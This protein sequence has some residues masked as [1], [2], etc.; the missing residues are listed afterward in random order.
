MIRALRWPVV[1]VLSSLLL[2]GLVLGGVHSPVRL[3]VS[4]WFLLV[5]TGMAFTP[6]FRIPALSTEL[7]V[8][9]ATSLAL[10]TVVATAIVLVGGLSATSGLF[11]L[12]GVCL[13][14]CA[15]QARG[16][17]RARELTA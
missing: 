12:Q 14:G 17:V 6:L 5:C 7:A 1:I 3:L 2:S 13:A 8:G 9:V 4:G 15:L 11:V 16:W 10:D